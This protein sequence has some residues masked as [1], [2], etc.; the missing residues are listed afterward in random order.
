MISYETVKKNKTLGA[1]FEEKPTEPPLE[2]KE[3]EIS[4]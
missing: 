2:N 3:P 1:F 4:E